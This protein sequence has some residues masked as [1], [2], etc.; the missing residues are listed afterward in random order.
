MVEEAVRWG[1]EIHEN[2]VPSVKFCCKP[3]TALKTFKTE[4]EKAVCG[5]RDLFPLR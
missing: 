5:A 4:N 3:K 1:Q 2:S